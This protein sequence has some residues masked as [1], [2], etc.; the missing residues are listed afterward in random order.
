M[1]EDQ[2]ASTSE[3]RFFLN[4][5]EELL[6]K[7]G[8][9]WYRPA[10]FLRQMDQLKQSRKTV[11]SL[12]AACLSRR[13]ERFLGRRRWR[14]YGSILDQPCH[15]GWKEPRTCLTLP[16]WLKVFPA[17]KIVFI[18]RNGVDVSDSLVRR[19]KRIIDRHWFGRAR[20]YLRSMTLRHPSAN[21]LSGFNHTEGFA[22][23]E[24]YI[25]AALD[26]IGELDC[27]H[28]TTLRFGS[29]PLT[30]TS[31]ADF[32]RVRWAR[33]GP[34]SYSL[35]RREDQSRKGL[36]LCV[37]PIP[38]QLLPKQ[39]QATSDET[40]CLRSTP[41]EFI[42][43]GW[44]TGLAPPPAAERQTNRERNLRHLKLRTSRAE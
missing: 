5:N 31:P 34:E 6:L 41:G 15:W 33:S 42:P 38:S 1:G 10:P 22:L 26:A 12:R 11:E 13:S 18:V 23:W 29:G 39:E 14:E 4:L 36:G 27:D 43:L 25:E 24:Q 17:A 32:G 3:S 8:A 9:S 44:Q 7:T 40:L 2:S 21:S 37:Q 30:R 19:E 20:Y 16:L 35:C 28:L